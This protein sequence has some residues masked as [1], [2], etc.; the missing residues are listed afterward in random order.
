MGSKNKF[1]DNACE[2]KNEDDCEE[3]LNYDNENREEQEKIYLK[4][5]SKDAEL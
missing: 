1:T 5:V 4:E 3:E 2:F